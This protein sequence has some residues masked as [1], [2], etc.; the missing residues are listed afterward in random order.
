MTG[1]FEDLNK[2]GRTYGMISDFSF[3]GRTEN[4]HEMVFELVFGVDVRC[5]LHHFSSLTCLK[6]S[7]GQ[8]WPGHGPKPKLKFSLLVS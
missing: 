3:G 6:G 4:G 7:W 8:V 5:L 1:A 2:L